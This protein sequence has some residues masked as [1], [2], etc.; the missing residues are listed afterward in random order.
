LRSLAADVSGGAME[1]HCL[2]VYEIACELGARRRLDLDRELLLC[3]A[4]LHDAGLYPG[5]AT[6]EA[7]VRDG[8]RLAERVL[9]PFEW[10]AARLQRVGDAIEFH[11]ELR[12]QWRAGPE[13]ELLR[14][15]DLVDL[16]FGRVRLGLDP[17]WLRD[18]AARVPRDGML[19]EIG[20]LVVKAARARP[21][22]LPAI[23]WRRR[24]R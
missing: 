24:R 20:G 22:T 13:V 15:A 8:R 21:L 23:F 4:W 2:R 6:Q 9:A 1:R 18:L 19:R 12:P 11:H 16:S 14:R 5:A 17:A 10:P 3:A 7:Y